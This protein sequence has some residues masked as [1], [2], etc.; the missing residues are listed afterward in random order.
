MAEG[1]A[2]REPGAPGALL[3]STMPVTFGTA[4]RASAAFDRPLP[5]DAPGA[6]P[7]AAAPGSS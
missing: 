4:A 5:G 3:V 7:G 1:P 6:A 2:L